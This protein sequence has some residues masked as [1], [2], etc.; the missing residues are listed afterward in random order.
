MPEFKTALKSTDSQHSHQVGSKSNPFIQPKLSINNPNDQYEKEAD[1]MAEK[2]MR[3]DG[4][5]LQLGSLSIPEIR[6]GGAASLEKGQTQVHRK[7]AA[8]DAGHIQ[9]KCAL[10]HE[11]EKQVQRKENDLEGIPES[12]D[13]A[14]YV[15]SLSAGGDALPN[16]VRNYYEPR[17]GY[18]FSNVRVHTDAVAAKSAQSINALAYTSGNHIVF[19]QGQFTPET[20]S[21]KRL[22]GHELTHTIQQQ[23]NGIQKKE[24]TQVIQTYRCRGILDANTSREAAGRTDFVNG[25]E[26]HRLITERYIQDRGTFQ[27]LNI[28]SGARAPYET[29]GCSSDVAPSETNPLVYNSNPRSIALCSGAAGPNRKISSNAIHKFLSKSTFIHG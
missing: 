16:E 23:D 21:G 20:E 2:V 12:A 14:S 22:L 3:M 18:D 1:A 25:V 13:L 11:E 5:G 24:G 27:R 4:A 8:S 9:K 15:G 28:P 7:V 6:P 29:E 17:F 19:S 26:A 10:C